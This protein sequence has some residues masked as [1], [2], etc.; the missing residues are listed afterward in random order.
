[1]PVLQ[2]P[3][4]PKTV[5]LPP[6]HAVVGAES[7][8]LVV[9]G[10][11]AGLGAA[12]GAA[13]AG[14]DVVLAERYAF[15]GGNATVALVMPLMSFHNETKQAVPGEPTRLLPTDHGEGGP[16][17]GGM[18]FRLLRRLTERGGAIWP[19]LETGYTVPFDPE[20]FKLVAMDLL[21]EA[22][23]WMLFHAFASG[24]SSEPD[25][26]RVVFESKSGPVVID[27]EVVVDC[28]GD[29]DVA[30][31]AGAPFEIG[32]EDGLTQPMTLMFRMVD[33][34]EPRF[35]QYVREHPDQWRGVHG[36]WELI[37]QATDA[38]DL[39]L[40]RED[41]L[42]FA[43]PHPHEVSVNSTRVTHCAGISVWDLSWAECASRR[44]MDQIA[45]F[46]RQRVPGFEDAYVGQSGVQ[47]GVRETR[48]IVG[49]YQL[50]GHDIL[51]ARKFPDAIARGAYPVDIHDPDGAGTVLRRVPQ[52]EAYDI[53]LRC[54]LPRGTDRLL[55]AGRCISGT[56]VAHSSY[57]VMPIAMA[58]GQAAGVCAALAARTGR[59]P[60][61]VPAAE[62]QRELLSQGASLREPAGR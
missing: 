20:Q 60:R 32:R 9:G 56:H 3:A 6:R 22:G 17:V 40:P 38:G 10:G 16:V 4:N 34:M 19:S 47:V 27:A 53:P 26:R 8:V 30:A 14:A 28:T 25:G 2:A 11:P 49:E 41:I 29:G 1:M 13:A 55:V 61:E 50:T 43:T 44:Q 35:A 18:L 42:F 48:R 54:L 39:K 31:F 21:H 45:R 33:V 24:S 59:A 46:L 62:V 7:Q 5:L 58:T 12:L 52:G 51:A 37:R 36:L 15:L 57:R 23:V